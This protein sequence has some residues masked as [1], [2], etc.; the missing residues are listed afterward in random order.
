[1]GSGHPLGSVLVLIPE[2]VL[3]LEP[4]PMLGPALGADTGGDAGAN[5]DASVGARA[6]CRCQ[7]RYQCQD[8][9]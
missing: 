3:M 7:R 1:M 2:L 9:W 4:G 5:I 8:W 6:W